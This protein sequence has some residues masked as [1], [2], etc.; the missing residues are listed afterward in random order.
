MGIPLLIDVSAIQDEGQA[1]RPLVIL[2]SPDAVT[3][4]DA[5]TIAALKGSGANR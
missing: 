5:R 4:E 3:T 2:A 1:G